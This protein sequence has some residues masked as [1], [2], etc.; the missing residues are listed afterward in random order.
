[1]KMLNNP[2]VKDIKS[3][4]DFDFRLTLIKIGKM[5]KMQGDN[6]DITPVVKE[7]NGRISI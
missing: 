5:G 7:I 3:H 6:I 1:M 2:H 4:F